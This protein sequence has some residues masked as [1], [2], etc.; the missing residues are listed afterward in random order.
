MP[1]ARPEWRPVTPM[2]YGRCTGC[3]MHAKRLDFSLIYQM[4]ADRHRAA[5]IYCVNGRKAKR[6]VCVCVRKSQHTRSAVHLVQ[7]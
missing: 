6:S 2:S 5:K 3:I 1:S 4:C 7:L